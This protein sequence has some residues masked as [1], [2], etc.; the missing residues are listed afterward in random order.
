MILLLLII[1]V[2]VYILRKTDPHTYY[3]CECPDC[4]NCPFPE[5]EKDV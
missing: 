4:K 1:G 2:A 3:R 5:C